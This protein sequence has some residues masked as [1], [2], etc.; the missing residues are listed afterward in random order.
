M[1]I[2]NYIKF[3]NNIKT[4]NTLHIPV[5]FCLHEYKLDVSF[6]TLYINRIR[7]VMK[8]DINNHRKL[9]KIHSSRKINTQGR[10]S[11]RHSYEFT[12][13]FLYENINW[14]IPKNV[15]IN[16]KS[17]ISKSLEIEISSPNTIRSESPRKYV[18]LNLNHTFRSIGCIKNLSSY[19]SK[20]STGL[21]LE[22]IIWHYKSKR[23][24][25]RNLNLTKNRPPLLRGL[26]L[27][28][29]GH[30]IN[31]T[32]LPLLR[33]LEPTKKKK[34]PPGILFERNSMLSLRNII[35]T[36]PNYKDGKYY[37]TQNEKNI[38][39]N[40]FNKSDKIKNIKNIE[41][42]GSKGGKTDICVFFNNNETFNISYKKSKSRTVQSWTS[43]TTW[44]DKIGKRNFKKLIKNLH[45]L[46]IDEVNGNVEKRKRRFFFGVS[47]H[48]TNTNKGEKYLLSKY[49]NVDESVFY[50]DK[51]TDCVYQNDNLKYDTFETFLNSRFLYTK[52]DIQDNKPLYIDIRYVYC[53]TTKSNMSVQ[54][55]YVLEY[56]NFKN[57]P[58][59]VNTLS[60]YINNIPDDVK[61]KP[62]YKS[63]LYRKHKK[64]NTNLLFKY[65]KDHGI[66]LNPCK[67]F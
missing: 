58:K 61:L 62:F 31:I 33:N 15:I 57:C 44:E 60:E 42:V 14:S 28:N 43:I 47:L 45:R 16:A 35:N 23:N 1:N 36:S 34:L 5:T 66:K 50:M 39:V 65:C 64:V 40:R 26:E 30:M 38:L 6:N 49:I 63:A 12:L 37:I 32:F 67:Y 21:N 10:S 41:Q 53:D 29:N 52:E 22:H 56:K 19:T 55:F 9:D 4:N 46:I 2:H 59:N 17:P 18:P 8:N 27:I 11:F 13:M 51:D 24:V 48:L 7:E 25:P 3:L 20:K 54:L